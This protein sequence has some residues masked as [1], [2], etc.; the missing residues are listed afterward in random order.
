MIFILLVIMNLE[1]HDFI[2]LHQ[3][4]DLLDRFLRRIIR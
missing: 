1:A 3:N 4:T 2:L